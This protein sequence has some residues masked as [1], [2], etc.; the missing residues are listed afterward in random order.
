[1]DLDLTIDCVLYFA[2]LYLPC[3]INILRKFFDVSLIV[4]T[5][6]IILESKVKWSGDYARGLFDELHHTKRI[7]EVNSLEIIELYSIGSLPFVMIVCVA[8]GFY[9]SFI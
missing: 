9:F 5:S 4:N 8:I 3:N 2:L 7:N 6:R 1:M